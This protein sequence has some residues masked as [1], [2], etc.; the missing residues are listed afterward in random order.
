M[1]VSELED[2]YA[3]NFHAYRFGN[4]IVVNETMLTQALDSSMRIDAFLKEQT[5]AVL[6]DVKY[7]LLTT[8]FDVLNNGTTTDV[9][10]AP[11]SKAFFAVDH[12]WKTP[13]AATFSNIIT[14]AMSSGT[15]DDLEDYAGDFKDASGKEMPLDFDIIIVK[16]GSAAEREARRLF[17]EKIAPTKVADINLYEGTKTIVATPMISTAN[18]ARWY[19]RSS[20]ATTRNSLRLKV[21]TMPTMHA[22]EINGDN[23]SVKSGV[24]GYWN[25][26]I[27]NLPFDWCT[28][29]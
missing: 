21:V 2:G 7:K 3:I 14:G 20:N 4:A 15:M 19:A 11:D 13:G 24:T 29:A 18:K 27:V 8:V 10:S 22:P 12:T 23:R 17:A 1:P 16:K 26:Q 28:G 6:R 25:A 9:A 5:A